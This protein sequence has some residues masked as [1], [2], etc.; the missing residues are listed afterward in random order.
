[1]FAVAYV[2][3]ELR[4][5]ITAHDI[6]ISHVSQIAL[7]LAGMMSQS[8]RL[9]LEAVSRPY[10]DCLG[11]VSVSCRTKFQMSRSRLEL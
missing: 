5:I 2:F 11:L 4:L 8:R 9:D 7:V 6:D 3:G 10:F 1:L